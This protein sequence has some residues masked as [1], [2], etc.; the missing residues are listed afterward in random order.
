MPSG[1]FRAKALAR[2]SSPEQ[3]DQ[4]LRLSSPVGRLALLA[5]VGLFA[6][7][8]VWGFF[9]SLSTKV[10]GRGILLRNA[11]MFTVT[12]QSEGKVTNLSFERGA[13]VDLGQNLAVIS[14]PVLQDKV[15]AARSALDGLEQKYRLTKQFGGEDTRLTLETLEKNKKNL[16]LNVVNLRAEVDK[17]A[18]IVKDV[19]PF[20]AQGLISKMKLFE[21]QRDLANAQERLAQQEYQRNGIASRILEQ[22]NR[23]QQQLLDLE[24]QI[25]AAKDG[26]LT[27]MSSLNTNAVVVSPYSGRVVEAGVSVGSLVS[28][29]SPIATLELLGAEAA[30]LEAVL[31][32][33]P[34]QGQRIKEGM[35]VQVFPDTARQERF[36][37]MLALV[38][39]VIVFPATKAEMSRVLQNSELVG[40][41][42][43]KGVKIEVHCVLVPDGSTVSGYKWSSSAGPDFAIDPGTM[44]AASV[45]V[46]RQRPIS[47][48]VPLFN[49]YVLGRG[50]RHPVGQQ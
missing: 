39:K 45:I 17:Y 21:Y 33:T 14:Q 26:L 3:L 9:G 46:K 42:A 36:G 34:E 43:D 23:V 6:A 44:C 32:F 41:L 5:G 10:Q 49:E 1:L 18:H 40:Q 11:G 28:S 38:T 22:K 7:L 20:V 15:A 2:I 25:A 8:L 27:A 37:G 16:D 47:L 24:N 35:V 48:V 13:T 29:G 31:Y 12:A 50:V 4:L 19:T 30:T